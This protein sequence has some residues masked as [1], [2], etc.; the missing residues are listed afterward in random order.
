MCLEACLPACLVSPRNVQYARF[1]SLHRRRE[2]TQRSVISVPFT[3]VPIGLG[4]IWPAWEALGN[5]TR[6]D[7][8]LTLILAGGKLNEGQSGA[9]TWQPV[10]CWW[11]GEC[12]LTSLKN[13]ANERRKAEEKERC[14]LLARFFLSGVLSVSDGELLPVISCKSAGFLLSNFPCG[15]SFKWGILNCSGGFS[16][17]IMTPTVAR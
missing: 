9:A 3:R 8:L 4:A 12:T 17:L 2:P 13:R 11:W 7:I 10:W 5:G 14:S 16:Q 1:R 15:L 6:Q